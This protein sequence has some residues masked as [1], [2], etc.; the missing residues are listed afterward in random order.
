[1]T[2]LKFTY[3]IITLLIIGCSKI[4]D[5]KPNSSNAIVIESSQID[6]E[7]NRLQESQKM[8]I[9]HLEKLKY[10]P[11]SVAGTKESEVYLESFNELNE[12]WEINNGTN[13]INNFIKTSYGCF[14][15]FIFWHIFQWN[16]HLNRKS[17]K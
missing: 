12:N 6:S 14:I 2:K 8:L 9:S 10:I 13:S 4:E 11:L 1:M 5:S 7:N 3:F 16:I 17:N 15:F